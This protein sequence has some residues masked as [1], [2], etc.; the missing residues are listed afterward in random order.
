MLL[1]GCIQTLWSF[2]DRAQGA[3]EHPIPCRRKTDFRFGFTGQKNIK[4]D[5]THQWC[6]SKT[7]SVRQFNRKLLVVRKMKAPLYPNYSF[8][9]ENVLIDIMIITLNLGT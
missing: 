9:D 2:W 8:F 6:I 1:G 3:S 5:H 7:N 4:N